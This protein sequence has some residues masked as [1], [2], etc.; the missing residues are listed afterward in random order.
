MG[1]PVGALPCGCPSIPG[2][3]GQDLSPDRPQPQ[4]AQQQIDLGQ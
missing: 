3:I 1:N 2:T 4:I